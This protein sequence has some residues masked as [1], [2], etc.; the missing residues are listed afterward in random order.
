MEFYWR[1]IRCTVNDKAAGGTTVTVLADTQPEDQEIHYNWDNIE[2]YDRLYAHR[3]L[4]YN[5]YVYTKQTKKGWV[6]DPDTDKFFKKIYKQWKHDPLDLKI[7]ITHE[8]AKLSLN[9]ILDWYDSDRA[10]QYLLERGINY[11]AK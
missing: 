10:M 7:T 6:C 9:Q 11:I 1:R 8:P 4:T 3:Y 5:F 2:E